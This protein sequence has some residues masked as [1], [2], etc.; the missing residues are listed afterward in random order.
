MNLSGDPQKAGDGHRRNEQHYQ[1][2]CWLEPEQWPER[3]HQEVDAEVPDRRPMKIV[4]IVE[5]GRPREV[6]LH[7]ISAHV[8]EQVHERGY[9]RI[10]E[11]HCRSDDG[12]CDRD[13]RFPPRARARCRAKRVI[14]R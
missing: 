12:H 4:K 11:R 9:C 14:G 3:H 6:E 10:D 8:A 13:T 1:L 2:D 7:A 5:V